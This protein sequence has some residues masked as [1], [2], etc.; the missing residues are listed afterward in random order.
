MLFFNLAVI[1]TRRGHASMIGMML[2]D[3]NSISYQVL[4]VNGLLLQRKGTSVK[5][6]S[7]LG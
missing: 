6:G 2:S 3:L 1:S 5:H 7:F 4:M